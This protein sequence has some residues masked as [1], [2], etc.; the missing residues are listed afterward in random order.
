M[1]QLTFCDY[2]MKRV[3]SFQNIVGVEYI[4]CTHCLNIV[5]AGAPTAP[6]VPTPMTDTHEPIA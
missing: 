5:G 2:V 1:K 4:V 3:S 6:M